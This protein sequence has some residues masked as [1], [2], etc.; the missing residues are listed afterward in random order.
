[1][2]FRIRAHGEMSQLDAYKA[3]DDAIKLLK[4]SKLAREI[5]SDL[6][7]HSKIITVLIGPG[8][9]DK[10]RH[11]TQ[12]TDSPFVG[13]IEW[14]P[15]FSLG[16]IDKAKKRPQQP[17]VPN[18]LEKKTI[19][20]CCGARAPVDEYGEINPAVCLMHEMGHVLQYLSNPDEFRGLFRFPDGRVN[21]MGRMDVEDINTAAVE[22]P[23]ILEL[24]A[25]GVNLGVRWGYYHTA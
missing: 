22:Q 21:H 15:T 3:F 8:L 16:V 24:K 4:Q 12:P 6:E 13:T 14:D 2:S 17:W 7:A 11:P 25:A 10:Y 20:N 9:E 5:I 18:K 19:W 1:M 23:V